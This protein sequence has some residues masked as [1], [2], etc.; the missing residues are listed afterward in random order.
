MQKTIT[1]QQQQLKPIFKK[2]LRIIARIA[3]TAIEA[4][5]FVD[6]RLFFEDDTWQ[7]KLQYYGMI[8]Y[9]LAVGIIIWNICL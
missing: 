4:Y 1:V 9:M 8:A 7:M 6:E 5:E 3:L 2:P